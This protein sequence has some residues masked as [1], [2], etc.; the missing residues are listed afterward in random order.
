MLHVMRWFIP[1]VHVA[2]REQVPRKLSRKGPQKTLKR[3][4]CDDGSTATTLLEWMNFSYEKKKEWILPDYY[5]YTTKST[6]IT[7]P[8]Y[9]NL[10]VEY[11]YDWWYYY[12]ARKWP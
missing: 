11:L 9:C 10:K 5:I 12:F 7:I 1:F 6:T 3:T 8:T 2:P 4:P